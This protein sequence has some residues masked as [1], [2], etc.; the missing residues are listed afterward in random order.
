MMHLRW[1]PLSLHHA[2][3]DWAQ[4]TCPVWAMCQMTPSKWTVLGRQMWLLSSQSLAFGTVRIIGRMCFIASSLLLRCRRQLSGPSSE[5]HA[6]I[7]FFFCERPE[8]RHEESMWQEYTWALFPNNNQSYK[9][10]VFTE[11]DL[12]K[13]FTADSVNQH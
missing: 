1:S 13:V 4:H 5:I 3:A 10:Q 11:T 6:N 8:V 2:H 12:I 9:F 7:F